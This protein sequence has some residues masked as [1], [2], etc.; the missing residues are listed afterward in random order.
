VLAALPDATVDLIANLVKGELPVETSLLQAHQ[1]TDD[2]KVGKIK[3]VSVT[4][5]TESL[6]AHR[7][8][9]QVVP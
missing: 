7:G 5:V 2:H 1:M 4:S 6:L 3:Q 8:H 9:A